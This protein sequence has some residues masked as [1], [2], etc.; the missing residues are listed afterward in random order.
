MYIRFIIYSLILRKTQP[1]KLWDWLVRYQN[2]SPPAVIIVLS[3][4]SS[5]LDCEDWAVCVYNLIDMHNVLEHQNTLNY[6]AKMI[7]KM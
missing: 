6:S 5:L 4:F 2:V 3:S 7:D 1:K